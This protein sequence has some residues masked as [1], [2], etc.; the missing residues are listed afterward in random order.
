MEQRNGSKKWRQAHILT[1]NDGFYKG[2]SEVI[3]QYK[4]F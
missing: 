3:H 4:G 2:R 1:V